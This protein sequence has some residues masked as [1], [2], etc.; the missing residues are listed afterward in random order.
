MMRKFGLYDVAKIVS[1][2]RVKFK[3]KFQKE[4]RVSSGARTLLL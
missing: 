2:C 1:C 3:V 4:S